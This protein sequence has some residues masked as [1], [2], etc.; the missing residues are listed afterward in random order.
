MKIISFEGIE[1]VGK[2]TQINLLKEYLEKRDYT[3]SI[4]R[5][6]GSTK[7]A[8]QIRKILLD[9][10]NNLAFETEL[11]LM[12]A[13]RSELVGKKILK[14]ENDFVLLDRFY[15]ASIAYQGYGRDLSLD[16]IESLV[17]FI[18]CPKPNLS[19]LLDISVEEGFSR[20]I[21][22]NKD[23]IES[24]G[25]VFFNKVREGYLKI[26]KSDKERFKIINASNN[27]ESIHKKIISYVDALWL[28]FHRITG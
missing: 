8:E 17:N 26:A 7:N 16:F 28:I 6:P 3:V 9:N 27:I 13:A 25:S 5:E 2:S 24:S 23:R 12:F 14:N 21:N 1:G 4:F 10:K 18:N 11:L 22:D 19:F 20:K 15:D